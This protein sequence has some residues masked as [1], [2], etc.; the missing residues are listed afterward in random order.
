MLIRVAAILGLVFFLCSTSA[1]PI[2]ADARRGANLIANSGFEE[3]EQGRPKG[4]EAL[5]D[6]FLTVRE[7][8]G[9]GWC[10]KC[11]SDNETRS[12]GAQQVIIFD[13]PVKDPLMF[14]AWSRSSGVEGQDYAVLIN[15]FYADGTSRWGNRVF[16]PRLA[17]DWTYREKTFVPEKPVNRVVVC[18]NFAR[19]KGTAW[20]DDITVA[21]AP[22]RISGSVWGGLVGDGCLDAIA[23]S[24]L[25]SVWTTRIIHGGREVFLQNGEGLT[26]RIE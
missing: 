6:G 5:N 23:N 4:W 21:L 20:F 13:P 1:A 15:V 16:Y 3:N 17:T 18:A 24:E 10:V 19:A 22:H 12:L 8:R 25:S 14:S 2:P 26:Q 7:G 9:G 11:E